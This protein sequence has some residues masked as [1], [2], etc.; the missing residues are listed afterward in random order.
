MK[1]DHLVFDFLQIGSQA[2]DFFFQAFCLGRK[3]P[4]RDLFETGVDHQQPGRRPD[5]V[6]CWLR[7]IVDSTNSIGHDLSTGQ[8]HRPQVHFERMRHTQI[9]TLFRRQRID[10]LDPCRCFKM[11]FDRRQAE[12]ILHFNPLFE[13]IVWTN[14]NRFVRP[15]KFQHRGLVKSDNKHPAGIVVVQPE[16]IFRPDNKWARQQSDDLHRPRAAVRRKLD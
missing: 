16:R 5:F 1:L 15:I 14:Q 3:F 10:R 8:A 11:K 6:R 2:V 7:S 12:I 9:A 4:I 13:K